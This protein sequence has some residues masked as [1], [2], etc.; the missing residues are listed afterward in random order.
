[1]KPGELR[2]LWF[3]FSHHEPQPYKKRPVLV[4]AAVGRVPD[5]AVLV[6]MVTSNPDRIKNP[7]PGDIVVGDWRASGLQRP[8]VIR[9][10]R[11]WTAEDRD[12]AGVLLG[13]VSATVLTRAK[14]NVSKLI[15]S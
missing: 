10:R 9:C 3:P 13:S 6:A 8:S 2:L 11:I 14:G 15:E 4:L 7:R 5:R 1:M 12:F